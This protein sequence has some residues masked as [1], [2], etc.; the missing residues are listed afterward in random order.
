MLEIKDNKG[1]KNERAKA[2]HL[3]SQWC[4][5]EKKAVSP[6]AQPCRDGEHSCHRSPRN[7]GTGQICG[8]AGIQQGC[9]WAGS[10]LPVFRRR[11]PAA[12]SA[13]VSWAGW[14]SARVRET[15]RL[16]GLPRFLLRTDTR[17]R[18]RGQ[19]S[20]M[21]T[22]ESPCDSRPRCRQGLVP[23]FWS[24]KQV[25]Q[26]QLSISRQRSTCVT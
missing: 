3:T 25:T 17:R 16:S 21:T 10:G 8:D 18:M 11:L 19:P 4:A 13:S 12:V 20:S 1:E 24:R 5:S 6:P 23:P 22:V 9:T 14:S 7:D 26:H 15:P 2:T